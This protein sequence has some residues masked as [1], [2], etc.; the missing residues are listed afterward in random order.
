MSILPRYLGTYL[1]VWPGQNKVES[2]PGHYPSA[3]FWL[4]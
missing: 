4:Q 2:G 3:R 1:P